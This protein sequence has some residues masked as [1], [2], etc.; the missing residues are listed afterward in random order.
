M[1][2]PLVVNTT[3]GTVWKRREETRDGLALYAPE[4]CGGCPEFVM[5]TYAELVEHGVAGSAD[6]LPM[7]VGPGPLRT[8]DVVEEELTG[9]SLSLFEEEQDNARLRLALESAR[10]GRRGLRARV[11]ELESLVA[12]APASYVLMEHAAEVADGVT[13]RIAPVQALREDDV[14][15]Q[16]VKLRGLLAGQRAAVEDPHDSPLHHTWRLGRDLP[17]TGSTK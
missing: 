5:A 14:S 2:A 4:K 1:S 9:V 10:R 3:D 16:V 12:N 8:L 15:P 11:A 7:P 13:R 6:V 17:E